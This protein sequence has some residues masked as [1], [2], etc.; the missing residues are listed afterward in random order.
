MPAV[1]FGMFTSRHS[2]ACRSKCFWRAI[3]ALTTLHNLQVMPER[4][5]QATARRAEPGGLSA[6]LIAIS[7]SRQKRYL[8]PQHTVQIQVVCWLIQQHEI[9]CHPNTLLLQFSAVSNQARKRTS[10]HSTACKFSRRSVTIVA[11]YY[12]FVM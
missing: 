4:V 5:P 7:R 3:I 12:N 2:T 6:H 1:R 9:L 10:S 8:R 11:P